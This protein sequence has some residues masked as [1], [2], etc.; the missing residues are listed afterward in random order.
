M[1]TL[2]VSSCYHCIVTLHYTC[3][4]LLNNTQWLNTSSDIV[5]LLPAIPPPCPSAPGE[6]WLCTGQMRHGS[7]HALLYTAMSVPVKTRPDSVGKL[8]GSPAAWPPAHHAMGL[9][10][11]QHVD[12]TMFNASTR[13]LVTSLTPVCRC[14][15]YGWRIRSPQRWWSAAVR[16]QA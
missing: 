16:M 6:C 10:S 2:R 15:R 13:D 7:A 9:L 3:F 11:T 5:D 1:Q 12:S 14:C 4:A 8:R